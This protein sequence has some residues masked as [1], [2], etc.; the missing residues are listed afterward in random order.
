[1]ILVGEKNKIKLFN[2]KNLKIFSEIYCVFYQPV[3][4]LAILNK[5]CVLV[6]GIHFERKIKLNCID[7]DSQKIL[8]SI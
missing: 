3:S 5:N 1:L 6:G 4:A 8:F 7:L 2:R